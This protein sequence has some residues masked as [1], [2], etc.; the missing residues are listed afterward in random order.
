MVISCTVLSTVC[1][2]A[3]PFVLPILEFLLMIV[4]L[5]DCVA[6]SYQL[7]LQHV[8]LVTQIHKFSII[9]C[10]WHCCLYRHREWLV[11]VRCCAF[12]GNA[13]CC[14]RD[15]KTSGKRQFILVWELM[16]LG[17]AHWCADLYREEGENQVRSG[18]M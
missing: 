14:C 11:L 7:F 3:L 8:D 10:R 15:G 9:N 17:A 18:L 16:A 6:T 1:Y 4:Q 13:I 2:T 12:D 5:D